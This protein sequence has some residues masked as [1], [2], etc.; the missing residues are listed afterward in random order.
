MVIRGDATFDVALDFKGEY[1]GTLDGPALGL[2]RNGW[3][4]KRV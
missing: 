4:L 3:E 1:P 2:G